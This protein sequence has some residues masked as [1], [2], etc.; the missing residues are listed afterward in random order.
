MRTFRRWWIGFLA[1]AVA[2]A[3]VTVPGGEFA[4]AAPGDNRAGLAGEGSAIRPYQI[5][6]AE[7]LYAFSLYQEDYLNAHLE[8]VA[9]IDFTG[10]DWDSQPWQPVGSSASPFTGTFDGN[11]HAIRGLVI[12]LDGK[13]RVGMFGDVGSGGLIQRLSLIDANVKGHGYVG[14]L[15]GRSEGTIRNVS[16]TGRVYGTH[17]RTGGAIGQSNGYV[18]DAHADVEV[19][20]ADWYTGGLIGHSSG[21]ILASSAS[22][23]VRGKSRVGGLVGNIVG[24]S[25][26]RFSYAT[27][28]VI[29]SGVHGGAGGLAG[30]IDSSSLIEFSYA[31]GNLYGDHDAG[32]LVGNIISINSTIRNAMPAGMSKA[33]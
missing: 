8:L 25:S 31:T 26:I 2:L 22:G 27:G 4:S 20:G 6:T 30:V 3:S 14:A 28:D 9:D 5:S 13:S 24:N 23:I 7:Q 19:T 15:A 11:G 21:D 10:W 16:V 17:E 12:H 29:D 18:S 33:N 1:V 32:G